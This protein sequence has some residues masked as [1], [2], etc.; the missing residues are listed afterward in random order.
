MNAEPD[1][2]ESSDSSDEGTDNGSE[3]DDDD[4][5]DKKSGDGEDDKK[6][7]H[8]WLVGTVSEHL[9]PR[10]DGAYWRGDGRPRDV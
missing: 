4:D 1:S 3:P 8:E 2:D 6:D 5:D 10:R 7:K 9:Q